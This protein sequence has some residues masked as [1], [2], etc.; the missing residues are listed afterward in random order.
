VFRQPQQ[1]RRW[2]AQE[3]LLWL[4]P[5]AELL[6]SRPDVRC[7]GRVRPDLCRSRGL[8]SG[9]GP[10]LLRSCRRCSQLLRSRRCPELLCS[11]PGLWWLQQLLQGPEVQEDQ[12]DGL[13]EQAPFFEEEPLLRS[14]EL[15]RPGRPELLC[16]GC[17]D[18]RRPSGW[19]LPLS[20]VR[21]N[22]LRTPKTAVVAEEMRFPQ[23]S[24]RKVL[25]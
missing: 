7:S 16:S 9:R 22:R 3:Q 24:C 15:L 2:S 6:R 12:P 17:P 20:P 13:D 21:Q 4:R 18:L 25:S 5:R 10:Q 23:R 1:R 11:G 19:L 8:C 14:D